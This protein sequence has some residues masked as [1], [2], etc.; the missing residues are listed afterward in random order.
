MISAGSGSRSSREAM[1]LDPHDPP[2]PAPA[3]QGTCR[4]PSGPLGTVAQGT[5]HSAPFLPWKGA[6]PSNDVPSGDTAACHSSSPGRKWDPSGAGGRSRCGAA[7]LSPALSRNLGRTA[8]VQHTCPLQHADSM[9]VS[10]GCLPPMPR[11]REDKER[12]QITEIKVFRGARKTAG[13]QPP[14]D[15]HVAGF[16]P[17]ESQSCQRAAV[18]QEGSRARAHGGAARS[19]LVTAGAACEPSDPV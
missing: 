15:A 4:P 19:G 7:E 3:Q 9:M 1:L 5:Q 16:C 12:L 6:F 18:T 14:V 10:S 11:S 8:T 17:P 2:S 13:Q